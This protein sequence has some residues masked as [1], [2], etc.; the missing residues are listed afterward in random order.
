[1]WQFT[2]PANYLSGGTFRLTGSTLGTS[3]IQAVWKAA[4]AIACPARPT[5]MWSCSTRSSRPRGRRRPL[6]GVTTQVTLALTMTFG[7][8]NRLIVI[9]VGRDTDNGSDTNANDACLVECVF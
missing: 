3:T 6:Q 8:A 5:A 7:A 2:L 4:A 1:M 9:F